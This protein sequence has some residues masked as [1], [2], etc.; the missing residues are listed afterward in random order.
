MKSYAI[1]V[2]SLTALLGAC[3][4]TPATE[5]EIASCR[6]MEGKMGLAPTHDHAEMKNQ[7]MNPMNLSHAR[8]QQILKE[9]Q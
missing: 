6:E 2:M 8:C 5:A 1:A 9:G 4:T 3:A 7:G